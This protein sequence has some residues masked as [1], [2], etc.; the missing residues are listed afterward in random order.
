MENNAGAWVELTFIAFTPRE[1]TARPQASKKRY[2]TTRAASKYCE[3][4]VM[5]PRYTKLVEA[6]TPTA[7]CTK[8]KWAC[9]AKAAVESFCIALWD[10]TCHIVISYGQ[11]VR[12]YSN[13][14]FTITSVLR[15][16]VCPQA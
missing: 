8:R 11:F 7:T 15:F 14:T 9:K 5:S 12:D 10:E 3:P 1:V 2:D 6:K 13:P 4:I 16:G